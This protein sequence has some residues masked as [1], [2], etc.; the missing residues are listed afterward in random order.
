M[1]FIHFPESELLILPVFISVTLVSCA[2]HNSQP[3]SSP[4]SQ[5]QSL[6]LMLCV[7][8]CWVLLSSVLSIWKGNTW[9][10]EKSLKEPRKIELSQ[11]CRLP[12]NAC[13]NGFIIHKDVFL[14]HRNSVG[15]AWLS[16]TVR[17]RP[18]LCCFLPLR[19]VVPINCPKVEHITKTGLKVNN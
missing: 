5:K 14:L 12:K 17:L 6:L 13:L 19:C 16:F 7:N 1:L 18:F 10:K 9:L 15:F 4:S 2:L 11:S 3:I 8:Y